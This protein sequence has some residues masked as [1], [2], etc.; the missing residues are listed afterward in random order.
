MSCVWCEVI[1]DGFTTNTSMSRAFDHVFVHWFR[2]RNCGVCGVMECMRCISEA[3]E[4]VQCGAVCHAGHLYSQLGRSSS[5]PRWHTPGAPE[6]GT[7]PVGTIATTRNK[8]QHTYMHIHWCHNSN[9]HKVI[10]RM[11][12]RPER[13]WWKMATTKSGVHPV[14]PCTII[15]YTIFSYTIILCYTVIYYTILYY[16]ILYYTILYYTILYYTILLCCHVATEY[17]MVVSCSV[18]CVA[19]TKAPKLHVYGGH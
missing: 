13:I 11:R 14:V 18:T 15:V 5:C 19:L 17:S 10:E 7:L 16:T 3:S 4:M 6:G 12:S 1:T 2:T 8:Q 9:T